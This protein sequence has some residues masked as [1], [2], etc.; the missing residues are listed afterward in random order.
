MSWTPGHKNMP[1]NEIADALTREAIRIVIT[2]NHKLPYTHFFEFI[3]LKIWEPY[4]AYLENVEINKGTSHLRNFFNRSPEPWF[5]SLAIA[6]Q[7][8]TFITRMRSKHYKLACIVYTVTTLSD[9]QSPH[10]E[11]ASRPW[12]TYA[13]HIPS[14]AKPATTCSAN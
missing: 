4:F 2:I 6:K 12:S 1:G 7:Q 10:V 9:P 14:T 11:K 13:G 3:K 8:V 5:Q